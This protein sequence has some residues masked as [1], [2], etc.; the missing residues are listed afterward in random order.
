MTDLIRKGT[1]ALAGTRSPNLLIRNHL[2]P[3]AVR[4]RA[5]PVLTGRVLSAVLEIRW[6][7]RGR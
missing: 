4:N 7:G 5:M 3:S 2:A 1:S 6:C